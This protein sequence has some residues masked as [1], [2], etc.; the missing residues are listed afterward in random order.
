[1]A[2]DEPIVSIES[3]KMGQEIR[4]TH[5]G[6]ITEVMFTEGSDVQVG[7][8]LFKIDTSKASAAP[9]AASTPTPA[10]S[11]PTPA[12]PSTPAA[13]PAAKAATP[14]PA[15]PTPPTRT[16]ARTEHREPITPIRQKIVNATK[17]T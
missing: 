1:M 3:D 13:T 8:V 7:E 5:A 9:A 17:E 14:T 15:A 10:A 4:T 2:E 12:A 16:G 11:T 6:E